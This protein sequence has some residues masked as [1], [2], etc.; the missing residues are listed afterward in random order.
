MSMSIFVLARDGEDHGDYDMVC[1]FDTLEAAEA[2]A[3]KREWSDY[4]ACIARADESITH[5]SPDET[6]YR[7]YWVKYVPMG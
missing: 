6:E 7:R 4:E 3:L 2:E 1:W 5:N